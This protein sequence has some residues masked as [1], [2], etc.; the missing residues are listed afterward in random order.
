MENYT[1][2]L[3]GDFLNSITPVEQA[4][5]DA[6]MLI[7][8]KIADA[9]KVKKWKNKDLLEA[10][11]KDNPSIIT[12]WLSGTHNFTMDTLIELEHALNIK[13][14]HLTDRKEEV[15]VKYH[16]VVKKEVQLS[17]GYNYLNEIIATKKQSNP[18]LTYGFSAKVMDSNVLIAQA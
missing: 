17:T 1:S 4:K 3:I 18:K 7:A 2:N 11:E 12:K 16:V 14:L 15:V 5:A 6:K 13:L 9:M 8:A 10:V